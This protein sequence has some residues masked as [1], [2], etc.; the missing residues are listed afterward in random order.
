MGLAK[1]HLTKNPRN[2]LKG[3]FQLSYKVKYTI[4]KCAYVLANLPR[5]TLLVPSFSS[6]TIFMH[7]YH[8]ILKEG[9]LLS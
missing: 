5:A 9:S 8:A 3:T 7:F 1:S 6:D 4:C 2:R